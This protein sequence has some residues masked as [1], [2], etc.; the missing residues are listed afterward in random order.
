MSILVGSTGFVGGH[1]ATSHPFELKFNSKNILAIN[2]R[3]TDL[4]VFA[5]L[6]GE[7]W[8]AN[9]NPIEDWGN[10]ASLAQLISTVRARKAILISTIDVYGNANEVDETRA[11]SYEGIE[12][13]GVNRAW[14]EVFFR[15]HFSNHLIIRLPA[16]YAPDLKKNLVYDLLHGRQEHIEKVNAYS[17]FQWFDIRLIWSVINQAITNEIEILNVSSEPTT[18]QEV[19]D[20]FGVTLLSQGKIVHYNMKSIHAEKFGGSAGYIYSKQMN[21]DGIAK[22]CAK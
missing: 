15:S 4:L 21:L 19:A 22:L 2:G 14:F 5:G 10:M 13:Y 3:D 7:K 12:K 11:P 20:I 6:P 8:R 17:T 1:L 9:A 18:A 16:L